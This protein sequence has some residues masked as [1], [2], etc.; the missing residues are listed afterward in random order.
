MG[1]LRA[2]CHAAGR[3]GRLGLV[4]TMG[5]L[6]AGYLSL[7][8]RAREAC[9]H[10][11]VTIFVNPLQ[12][13]A[14]EDLDRYPRRE[15]EDA[16]LLREAGADTV[17]RAEGLLAHDAFEWT[18]PNRVRAVVGTLVNGNPSAFH[19]PDGSGYAFFARALKKLDGINPQIADN[20]I[21]AVSIKT[22][23]RAE[24]EKAQKMGL[25]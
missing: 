11:A 24:W 12:F 1:I 25:A 17:A 14:H 9:D 4:P 20:S 3:D 10:V 13:G 2:A 21:H 19:A 22:F 6:H 15:A 23:T 5:A 16:E 18:L 7:V 8:R